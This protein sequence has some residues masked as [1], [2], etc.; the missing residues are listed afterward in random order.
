MFHLGIE[1]RF[2]TSLYNAS[3][4][5]DIDDHLDTKDDV[6]GTRNRALYAPLL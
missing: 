3:T 6:G 5:N 2:A 4:T 1:V